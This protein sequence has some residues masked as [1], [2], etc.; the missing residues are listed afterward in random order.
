MD[1]TCPGSILHP[2]EG[3]DGGAIEG[4]DAVQGPDPGDPAVVLVKGDD[5]GRGQSG[6]GAAIERAEGPDGG[7]VGRAHAAECEEQQRASGK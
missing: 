2:A 3:A 6:R 1:R 4:G 7:E 5:G